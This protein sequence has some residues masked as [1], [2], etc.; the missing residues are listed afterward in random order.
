Q[1]WVRT[2]WEERRQQAIELP[3]RALDIAA[4]VQRR[5]DRMALVDEPRLLARLE[6][7]RGRA[8][9]EPEQAQ[10]MRE[11]I[12]G[13]EQ[14][15]REAGGLEGGPGLA[16]SQLLRRSAALETTVARLDLAS[17]PGD[18]GVSRELRRLQEDL[19]FAVKAAH[20]IAR[21][22]GAA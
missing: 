21:E 4:D 16:L 10:E 5:L 13:V 11:A 8:A 3:L 18:T 19:G 2:S 14:A 15:C 1:R 22:Q 6:E 9:A 20:Q 12:A 17:A 7:L